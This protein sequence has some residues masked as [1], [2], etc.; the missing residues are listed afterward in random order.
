VDAIVT[1]GGTPLP[2]GP[3]YPY[4]QGK[5]KAILDVSGKLMVQRVLDALSGSTLIERVVLVGLPPSVQLECSH[6][7]TYLENAGSIIGNIQ[8]GVQ[9]LL[10]NN[11][12]AEHALVVSSDIPAIRPEMVDWLVQHVEESDF[13]VYYSIIER[14]N[15]E[16]RF[17]GSKRTYVHL[18]DG[19]FC[20]GDMNAIRLGAALQDNPAWHRVVEARKNPLKQAQLIG[21]D[22]LFLLLLR[23]LSVQ[24]A[25]RMI[26]NRLKIRGRALVCPYSEIGMDV[27]KPFQLDMLR[28]DLAKQE[29]L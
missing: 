4:T 20:G 11:R 7:L 17:P 29:G 5:A 1:A 25:E 21:F 9:E 15:M 28:I 13:D 3:L 6:S 19:E 14:S 16:R 24:R 27:D 12:L 22:T 26:C 8:V 18:K 2:G 23:L 10:K